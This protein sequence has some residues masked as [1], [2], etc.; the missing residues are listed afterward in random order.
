MTGKEKLNDLMTEFDEMGYCPTTLCSDPEAAAKQWQK[1]VFEAIEQMK[2]EIRNEVQ[3]K[4]QNVTVKTIFKYNDEIE[5]LENDLINTECNLQNV[6]NELEQSR[7]ETAKEIFYKA[8]RKSYF[9]D[10]GHYGKDRHLIDIEELKQIIKNEYG[11]EV[12]Q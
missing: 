4:G 12:E 10:G 1:Q 5:A 7:K 6:T 11:V 8:E 3:D 2:Q 9:Q